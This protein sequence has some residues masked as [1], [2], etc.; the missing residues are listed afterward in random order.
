MTSRS[1]LTIRRF[2]P[3]AS[4]RKTNGDPRLTLSD[5]DT[6][7]GLY[8]KLA[9]GFAACGSR[10]P[11]LSVHG[12]SRKARAHRRNL[13][14][15]QAVHAVGDAP[16]CARPVPA[17]SQLACPGHTARRP[18]H[19]RQENIRPGRGNTAAA[20][21]HPA[22]NTRGATGSNST[23]GHAGRSNTADPIVGQHVDAIVR[24]SVDSATRRSG[25]ATGHAPAACASEATGRDR[26]RPA[27]GGP[28]FIRRQD[29]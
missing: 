17:G 25:A 15:R 7:D 20:G 26:R 6:P 19:R 21:R 16:A 8:C 22:R 13:Q 10:R 29:D 2:A 5:I 1:R 27:A 28:K 14:Q 23:T 24:V 9:A 18:G 11:Q 4:C 3:S 12:A